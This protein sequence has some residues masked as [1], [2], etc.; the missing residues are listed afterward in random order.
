MDRQGIEGTLEC[1]SAP[2]AQLAEQEAFNLEA[3]SS[4]LS[5]G[6]RRHCPRHGVVVHHRLKE[7]RNVSGFRYRCGRCNGEAVLRRKRKVKQILVAEAGGCCRVC[8]YDRCIGDLVFHHVDPA[9]KRFNL[10]SCSG[11]SL[12]AFRE[13]A[14]KCVLVCANCHGEIE[15][16]LVPSPPAPTLNAST[17]APMV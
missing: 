1:E 5:G 15:A 17:P 4:N 16:G 14:R 8:G 13:E 6:I 12:A 2:V 3:E 9:Q 7:P 11:K 10:S